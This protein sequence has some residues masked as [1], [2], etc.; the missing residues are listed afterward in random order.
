[1]KKYRKHS[2]PRMRAQ[3]FPR[4]RSLHRLLF[5]IYYLLFIISS[6]VGLTSCDLLEFDVDSD[7]S[8]VAAEMSLNYDTAYV[9]RGDTL[10][11]LPSFKPDTLNIR[12]IFV[13]SSDADVVSVN[14]LTGR[15]E[16]VGTGWARLYVESVS[17][18]LLDSCDV[19]VMEP[20]A[21][22]AELDYPYETIIYA[23]ITVKGKPLTKDMTVG[24]FLGDECRGVAEALT[25]HGV[26]LMQLRVGSEDLTDDDSVPD[27]P[28]DEEDEGGYE[29][30]RDQI[31]FRCYDRLYK[32]LYECPAKVN[33]DGETH[34]TLS[35]LY[36]IAF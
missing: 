5:S 8:K 6:L 33:F 31:V 21:A 13:R 29:V 12:D 28:D 22:T 23:D 9:M 17:A 27:L 15:I 36:K 3:D 2:K 7:L 18:R 30:V 1:M 14:L 16:A 34:G 24:A 10:P 4:P 26:S 25:F 20:W 19:C 11:L 35:N 32:Q